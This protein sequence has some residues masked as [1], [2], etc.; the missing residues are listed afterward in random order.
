[1]FNLDDVKILHLEPTT[2]CNAKCPQCLRTV[3]E[4]IDSDMTIEQAMELFPIKFVQQLDKMLL[5]SAISF[6]SLN[7]LISDKSIN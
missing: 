5:H 4:Y 3:T 6:M 1:M 7:L 2:T